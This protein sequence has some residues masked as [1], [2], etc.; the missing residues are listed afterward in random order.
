MWWSEKET[1]TPRPRCKTGT[2]GTLRV[3]PPVFILSCGVDYQGT[4]EVEL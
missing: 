3:I 4:T 2:W 1:S